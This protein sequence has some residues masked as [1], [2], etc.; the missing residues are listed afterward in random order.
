MRRALGAAGGYYLA[1]NALGFRYAASHASSCGSMGRPMAT[2]A[3]TLLFTSSRE[4]LRVEPIFAHP[5]IGGIDE[6]VTRRAVL[7][8]HG[9]R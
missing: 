1:G 5:R 4:T 9:L 3:E 7:R 8:A 2:P 6:P